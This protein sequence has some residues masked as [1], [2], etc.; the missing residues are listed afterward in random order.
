MKKK[1][2]NKNLKLFTTLKKLLKYG[3]TY[4]KSLLYAVFLLISASL[5]EILCPFLISLFI[6]HTILSKNKNIK[7]TIILV[8]SFVTLQIFSTMLN[9]LESVLI[10]KISMKI[11]YFLRKLVMKAALNQPI[12]IFDQQPIGQ[13]ISKVTNDTEIIKELYDSVIPIFIRSFILIIIMIIAIFTLN[14]KMALIA[15]TIFPILIMIILIYQHYSIPLLR[16]SRNY[17]ANINNQFNECISGMLILQQF[18][19]ENEYKKKILY[20]CLQH[21]HIK[22]RILKLDGFLLRPFLSLLTSLVLSGIM[23]LLSIFPTNFFEV[24]VLYAFINYLGRLNEPLL[25]ITSQQSVLQQAIVSGERI[26]E[27][28]NSKKQKYG[29]KNCKILKGEIIVENVCFSYKN[30]KNYVL[31][32]INCKIFDKEFVALVGHTGSGKTTFVNLLMGYYPNYTGNIF[33]N[34]QLLNTF[35]KS[36]LR[37]NISIVQQDPVIFADTIYNNITLGENISEKKMWQILKKVGLVNLVQSMPKGVQSILTEQG[38][39]LSLGQ[40][41][42]ISLARILVIKPKILILDEATS[43]IDSETEN[44]IQKS[45]A[46]IHKTTT[47]ISIAHRFSTIIQANKII[48][49]DKGK[50]EEIGT[51][52]ELLQ[53]KGKYWKMYCFHNKKKSLLKDILN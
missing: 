26:F 18:N 35:S 19:Q 9:F 2:K 52:K 3:I 23:T 51:H 10:N 50:I 33:I 21:Y 46:I 5:F 49:F 7:F 27:L 53:K 32:N 45:I 47:I 17:F 8:L 37:N 30:D 48:C 29:N 11:V 40:K 1:K 38:N 12:S 42:L 34:N 15:F 39:N 4:K 14:W 28:I 36:N 43:N 22:M 6:K 41:Q 31:N 25:A 44:H 16:M 24:S 13:I 20:S